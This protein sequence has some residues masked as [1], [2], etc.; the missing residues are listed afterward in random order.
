MA[1]K[2]LSVAEV[3]SLLEDFFEEVQNE[4]IQGP[5]SWYSVKYN[6][7]MPCEVPGLGTLTYT[8]DYGGEGQGDSY[9]VVF[10]LQDAETKRYFKK[11]GWYQSYAGGE[12]DGDLQEV[13][14]KAA[15]VI[16]WE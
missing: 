16:V 6:E 1:L 2:D 10:S 5:E 11:D 15:T 9:W 3:S 4:D 13:T 14:P 12:L 8:E 7:S